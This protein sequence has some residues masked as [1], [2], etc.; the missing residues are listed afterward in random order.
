MGTFSDFR[1]QISDFRFHLSPFRFHLSPFTFP[2]SS[3][4]PLHNGKTSY[5]L[6]KG[7]FGIPFLAL[8]IAQERTCPLDNHQSRGLP[9]RNAGIP[10][11][12]IPVCAHQTDGYLASSH[13]MNRA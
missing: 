5:S 8:E 2:L 13:T 1:F 9:H 12:A 6:G 11:I 4:S 3:L 7:S 10:W